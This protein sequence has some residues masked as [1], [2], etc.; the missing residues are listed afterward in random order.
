MK[1][2]LGP[3]VRSLRPQYAPI[4]EQ[5]YLL[6]L[7]G[8]LVLE[9]FTWVFLQ[10]FV[11]TAVK[12]SNNADGPT[13]QVLLRKIFSVILW[14]DNLLYSFIILLSARTI[15]L[16]FLNQPSKTAVASAAFRRSLRLCFPTVVALAIVKLAFLQSGFEYI[17]RFKE[18]TGN[19][20]FETP[21]G[22]PNFL[23]FF[24]SVYNLF[25]STNNFT[26]QA[27]NLAFPSQTLW[28]V[29]VVY[30]QSY[31][32][33]MTM[34]IIPYTRNRWRIQAYICFIVAAWWV[35]SWAWYS[36][37]G[38]LLADATTNMDFK[39][40]SKRGIHI[41]RSIRLPSV[42]VYG[43]LMAGGLVMQYLWT[44]WRPEFENYELQGHT[45]LYYTG[46][47]NTKYDLKQPQARDDNYLIILGFLLLLESSDLLQMI[48]RNP[49]F[50]YLGRRSLST[51]S[52][53][54]PCPAKCTLFLSLLSPL[55]F[56]QQLSL[57]FLVYR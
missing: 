57:S 34:V 32:I 15:C 20:S 40:V 36:I 6:G 43:I 33:Y 25:W 39:P 48:F 19:K 10:T 21:A 55:F 4:Y 30:S 3:I 18:L 23:V 29:N 50:V 2:F 8:L 37:T 46:G 56:P 1:D 22:I 38:L 54:S 42:V 52:F 5:E 44:A 13:Y 12:N 47:L 35:Q 45:G 7:R 41:W 28:I 49:F 53:F 14:N 26:L 9:S 24:N 31:T 16:P 17:D 51:F 27:G 11:P